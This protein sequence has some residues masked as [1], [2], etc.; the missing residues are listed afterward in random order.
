MR[1]TSLYVV[2]ICLLLPGLIL[3]GCG[4][5]DSEAKAKVNE[6]LELVGSSKSLLEDLL[7][8]D[9]RINDLGVRFTDVE[10]SI[11]EGK[12]LAE[13]ALI[14]VDE[15]E[16]RYTEARDLLDEVANME[17]AG[18]YAEYAR[19]ALV[20]VEKELEAITLNRQLLTDVWDMLDVLPLAESQEQLSFYVEEIDR[21]T[22]EI[23]DLLQQG[24]EAAAVADR[25][26][27]EHGL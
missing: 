11:A 27:E 26:Y 6:A 16:A 1:R 3:A 14:D 9:E 22:R 10:D 15:L 25:Y 21:L 5:S 7:S 13:M 17:G 2:A 24:A 19:L 18:D 23:T 4:G 8:L 20:A 12:S